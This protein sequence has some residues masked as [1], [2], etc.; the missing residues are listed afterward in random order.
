M[1]H[2]GS[3]RK[4]FSKVLSETSRKWVSSIWPLRVEN[5]RKNKKITLNSSLPTV[6]YLRCSITKESKIQIPPLPS[7]INYSGQYETNK[8]K[9]SQATI[10][11]VS[12]FCETSFYFSLFSG[13]N[14]AGKQRSNKEFFFKKKTKIEEGRGDRKSLRRNTHH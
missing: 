1:K 7:L 14:R 9:K 13:K 4:R 2:E 3:K 8:E 6:S 12:H 5:V 11:W 10:D